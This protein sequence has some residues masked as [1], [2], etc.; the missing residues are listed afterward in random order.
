MFLRAFF[1]WANI[2]NIKTLADL[3]R[4][5]INQSGS[6]LIYGSALFSGV[7]NAEVVKEATQVNTEVLTGLVPYLPFVPFF[8]LVLGLVKLS[9]DMYKFFKGS[10]NE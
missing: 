3:I 2:M 9:F 10:S 8:G 5:S 1:L 4:Y 6:K 7:V